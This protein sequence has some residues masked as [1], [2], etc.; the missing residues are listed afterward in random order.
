MLNTKS[1]PSAAEC[2]A[3]AN[4]EWENGN[5]L[6]AVR[7][8]KEGAKLNDANC[9]NSLGF[10]YDHG[11]GVTVDAHMAMKLYRKAASMG[12]VSATANV[13]LN[14]MNAGNIRAAGRWLE[15][16]AALGEEDSALRLGRLVTERRFGVR[17]REAAYR[18]L[19]NAVCRRSLDASQAK[20]ARDLMRK[21]REPG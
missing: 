15:K 14:Y 3:K 12:D 7:W 5:H 2:F 8:F 21:L 13:A 4:E 9:I 16:A 20:E 6:E 19:E 11:I 18:Y 1:L 17:L 10:F